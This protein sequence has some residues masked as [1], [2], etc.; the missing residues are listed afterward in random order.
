M[1]L[2][3]RGR[4]RLLSAQL[5]IKFGYCPSCTLNIVLYFHKH[6]SLPLGSYKPS[7]PVSCRTPYPLDQARC[8]LG[9]QIQQSIQPLC[10]EV[11]RRRWRLNVPNS[12]T[13]M[14]VAHLDT[15]HIVLV[16]HEHTSLPLAL[17]RAFISIYQR[18][19]WLSGC[20]ET[21]GTVWLDWAIYLTLG[22][23]SKHLAT[24]NLPKSPTILINFCKGVKIY[25]FW[26]TFIDIWQLFTGHAAVG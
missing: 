6:N 26:A 10:H 20:N 13:N 18:A 16:F 8:F 7:S 17:I 4:W 25:H 2:F 12:Q 1:K 21:A 22:N 3:S 5:S 11:P 14:D 9:I 23:F 19:Q 24:I 15:V